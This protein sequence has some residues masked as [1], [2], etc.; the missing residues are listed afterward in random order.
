MTET[1]YLADI[2]VLL[3]AAVITRFRGTVRDRGEHAA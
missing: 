2:L 1:H 3:T